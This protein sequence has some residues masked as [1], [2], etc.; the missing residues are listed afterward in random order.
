MIMY[1]G[2]AGVP[3]SLMMFDFESMD[4][5]KAFADMVGHHYMESEEK[6]FLAFEPEVQY[7]DL[8]IVY[9]DCVRPDGQIDLKGVQI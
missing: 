7:D 3:K 4:E 8:D 6:L 5:A 2:V 1:L 9:S